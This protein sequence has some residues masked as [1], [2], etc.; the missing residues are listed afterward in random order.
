MRTIGDKPS[1]V[2][3]DLLPALAGVAC[4]VSGVGVALALADVSSPLRA[5]FVLFFLFAGPA[6]GLYAA[7]PRLELAARVATAAAGAVVIAVLAALF[8]SPLHVLTAGGAVAAVAAITALL[9]LRTPFRRMRNPEQAGPSDQL[10]K[11]IKRSRSGRSVS[12]LRIG[13]KKVKR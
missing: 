13:I 8:R 7:L 9:F 10:R 1:G 5:P 12:D 6:G 2:R 11:G 4:A 3:T